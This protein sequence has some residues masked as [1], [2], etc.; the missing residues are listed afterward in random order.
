MKTPLL[1]KAGVESISAFTGTHSELK[2][3]VQMYVLGT[4]GKLSGICLPK[5]GIQRPVILSL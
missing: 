3:E 2:S 5:A 4:F 1:W